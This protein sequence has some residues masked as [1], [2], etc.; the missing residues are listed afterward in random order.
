MEETE[1]FQWSLLEAFTCRNARKTNIHQLCQLGGLGK[2]QP[3]PQQDT[4][5]LCT[6]EL[7]RIS[8]GG[9]LQSCG[10]GLRAHRKNCDADDSRAVEQSRYTANM[11]TG[12][13]DRQAGFSGQGESWEEERSL[14][15]FEPD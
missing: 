6:E 12:L 10:Q 13:T 2:Q 15:I 8:Q 11:K 1:H 7:K 5:S 3:G 14:R 4:G 9:C